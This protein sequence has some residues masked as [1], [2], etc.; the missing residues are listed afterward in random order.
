MDNFH[1]VFTRASEPGRSPVK[2]RLCRNSSASSASRQSCLRRRL[3]GSAGWAG[4]PLQCVHSSRPGRKNIRGAWRPP[5][6]PGP[7]AG[8]DRAVRQ[9]ARPAVSGPGVGN[10]G[11]PARS[12]S[13]CVSSGPTP[14]LVW[15]PDR[16]DSLSESV[17]QSPRCENVTFLQTW[18]LGEAALAS[19]TNKFQ[20]REN[21]AIFSAWI[22]RAHSC[23]ELTSW[24]LWLLGVG[25]C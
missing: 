9:W 21:S 25:C 24:L 20:L 16:G 11:Y 5:H 23:L 22:F 18:N 14:A 6:R 4:T 13:C 2:R 1:A 15:A 8:L 3:C 12:A 19:G 17:R 10:A 7:D